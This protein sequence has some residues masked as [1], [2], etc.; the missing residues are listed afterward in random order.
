MVLDFAG[1]IANEKSAHWML[2]ERLVASG[3]ILSV[4]MDV[5]SPL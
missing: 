4:A 2:L 5:R 3:G 1:I